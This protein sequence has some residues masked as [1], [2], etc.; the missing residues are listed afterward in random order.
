M[1][2]AH[3]FRPADIRNIALLG[4]GGSGK[5]TL[6]EAML[7]SAHAITRMGSVD[8]GSTTSDYLPEAKARHHSTSSSLLFANYELR[9][10]NIIDTPGHPEF[11]GAPLA[12][13]SAVETA[14]LVV[15]ATTGIE[16]NT[17]R[18][19]HAAGEAGLARMIVINKM[20]LAADQLQ[21]RLAELRSVFGER[22]HCI[23]LPTH[24]GKDVI[25]CFDA[26][27]GNADFG[28]VAEIHREM[29]ESVVEVD[30]AEL[31]KY[32]SGKKLDLSELRQTF[33]KAM[34]LGQV[35]PVLFTNA[36][37]RVGIDDL[38]H[39][40]VEEA[41]SPLS[42]R[43]RRL[44]RGE[45]LVE[46]PC[47]PEKPLLAHV[48][49]LT[50]DPHLGTM[51]MIRVLQGKIDGSTPF[52]TQAGQKPKKANHVLKVEGRDHPELD[53]IAYAGDIVA[54]ARAEDMHVD[55]ILRDPA[56]T[57]EYAAVTLASPTPMLSLAIAAKNKN[58]EVKLGTAVQK[59]L[60]EDPTLRSTQD[61]STHELVISGIGDVHLSV[62]LD[63]LKNRFHLEVESKR[64]T[65]AYRETI[66]ARAEGH[67]RHKKQTGGAGQ[68]A[69]VFLRV[70]PLRRGEGMQFASEVFGGAIP[71]QF[72]ASVEKGV[73][74]AMESGVLAGFPVQDVRVVVYDGKAH[75]V[76]SKDIAFR[77]AGKMA[78]RDA[79]Q[80]AHPALL[81]P[82]V[83]LEITT[84][85]QYMGDVTADLKHVRARVFGVEALPGGQSLIR[86][87]APLGELG[88]YA[89]QLKSLTGGQGSFTMEPAHDDFVPAPLAQRVIATRPKAAAPTE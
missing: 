44:R 7:H 39:V 2:K 26:E 15:S 43:P 41:P 16:L 58:D 46:I 59:L 53:A 63:V 54:I 86:A 52:I 57:E 50:N 24:G 89:S 67:Y 36:K 62:A 51:A 27:S 65:V 79:L 83:S 64:P 55:Q 5:T 12:A 60:E 69:E 40:L 37:D 6:A 30:D 42:G 88:T 35:V 85:E 72:I 18:L 84:P 20:D 23:N 11:I 77:T 75:A 61:N 87:E 17:R 48:F 82:I 19:F 74:D 21:T 71:T 78:L 56:V 10:V 45:N 70:E 76:D 80:K 22:L 68:F 8:D 28:S 32:L 47:D 3:A 13:L 9:E 49:K 25:D 33:V 29:V 4:H 81:E 14:I 66:T 73:G 1:N 31:E 38:L 34:S